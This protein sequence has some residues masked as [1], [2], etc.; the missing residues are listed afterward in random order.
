MAAPRKPGKPAAARK[1]KV[2]N[3]GNPAMCPAPGYPGRGDEGLRSLPIAVPWN[4]TRTLKPGRNRRRVQTS[5]ALD[6]LLPFVAYL[7]KALPEEAV[8][9][10]LMVSS[11]SQNKKFRK[12]ATQLFDQW[13]SSTKIDVRGEVNIYTCQSMIGPY[14]LR[15]GE[16]F[17]NKVGSKN[18]KDYERPLADKNFRALQLQF[19]R[20]DQI[21]TANGVLGAD[22]LRWDD[23]IQLDDLDRAVQY[24]VE[25]RKGGLEFPD[26]VQPIPAAQMIHL[27]EPSLEGIH[28]IPWCSR[29]EDC[30]IDAVDL[31]ALSKHADKIKAALQGVIKTKSGEVPKG[32]RQN[33]KRAR[34]PDPED[35]TKTV[36]DKSVRFYEI[37]G[38]VFM[39]VLR[40]DEDISFFAGQTG[41][42]FGEQIIML[43]KEIAYTYMVPPEY[44]VNLEKLGSAGVRMILRKVKKLLDRIRRP[45]INVFL[46]QV[47]EMVI[48]DFIKRGKL[49]AVDDWNCI[50]C[51]A[52]PDPSIDA[53]R[54]ERAEQERILSFTSSVRM[55][56]DSLG[57]DG[58]TIRHENLDELADNIKYGK[59]LSLPWWLCVNPK[60]IQA[61]SGLLKNDPGVEM[62]DL[63][64]QVKKNLAQQDLDDPPKDGGQQNGGDTEGD[65]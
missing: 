25:R 18:Q 16:L 5:R 17:I 19:I 11:I 65:E 40:K 14:M 29:G 23:G 64:A 57:L 1:P 24:K 13:G 61:L 50:Q 56:A 35:P 47:W 12:L 36:E 51:R 4:P 53:G 39:P 55:Y 42:T 30:L 6:E 3:T 10:G 58:D 59:T 37:G 34:K 46:Q 32:M 45:Y 20:R 22:P 41:L 54:D 44:V 43:I 9:D 33:V 26:S 49:E 60:I 63:K 15:D 27:K 28:G 8:G 48:G 2:T 31:R 62:A 21:S 7:N 52:A 38:G